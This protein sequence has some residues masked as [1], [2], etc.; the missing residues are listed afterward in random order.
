MLC[1]E[2][3]VGPTR[4]GLT[5]VSPQTSPFV[6]YSLGSYIGVRVLRP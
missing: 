6:P 2:R 3:I 1:A 5:D 4:T